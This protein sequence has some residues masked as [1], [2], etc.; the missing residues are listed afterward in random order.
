MPLGDYAV[1][2][3][4]PRFEN[5]GEITRWNFYISDDP[6]NPVNGFKVVFAFRDGVMIMEPQVQYIADGGNG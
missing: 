5:E 4:L 1:G 6:G 2:C 3:E